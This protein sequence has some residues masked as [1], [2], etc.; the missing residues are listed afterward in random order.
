[1]M[2]YHEKTVLCVIGARH[3]CAA[4]KG[5]CTDYRRVHAATQATA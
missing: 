2:E 5:F 3:V 1:M 4:S